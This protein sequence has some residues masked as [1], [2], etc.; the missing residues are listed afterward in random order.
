LYIFY[1]LPPVKLINT[2]Y[3]FYLFN[4]YLI[5]DYLI[6]Y[7]LSYLTTKLYFIV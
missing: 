5:N 2:D 1:L 7:Y 4:D 3:L 6:F